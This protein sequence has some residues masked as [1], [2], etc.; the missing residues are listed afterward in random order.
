MSIQII[1]ASKSASR[2]AL[3][4]NAGV[5][6]DAISSDVDEN[7][8]K[9]QCA[10]EGMDLNTT[11][12]RLAEAK[13]IEVSKSHADKYIIGADQILGLDGRAFDKPSSLEEAAVRIKEFSGKAHILHNG[14][15]VVKNEEVIWRH[16][17]MPCLKM[18]A[19]SD[20]QVETYIEKSGSKILS[21][22]GAYMLEDLGIQLFEK[23]EGDYFSILGLPL[24]PLL[25]FL[26]GEGLLEI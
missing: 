9:Q 15:C 1:L 12:M 11:C 23:I 10:S 3:L 20:E 21:S 14:I 18:R 16:I 24:L 19:L 8:I 6:H 7:I 5:A 17:E 2:R 25:E 13:A 26:R 4:K 22:V